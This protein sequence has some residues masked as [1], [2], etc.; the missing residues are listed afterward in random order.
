MNLIILQE[1][2]QDFDAVFQ[3][4]KMAFENEPISDKTEHYLV[5]RLRKSNA[6]I[7]ELS[8]VAETENRIIGHILLTKIQIKNTQNTFDS[9]A[10]APVSVH[11]VYQRKGVGAKLIKQ[12][13]KSA[14][15]LG[16]KAIILIGHQDYYPRFSYLPAHTFGIELPFKIPPENCMAIELVENG[17]KGVTGRV[18]YPAEFFT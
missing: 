4:I 12:A 1:I 6:F 3:L 9:F 11:P 8:L 7:P 18:E 10:L 17:L 16:Y 14:T 2:K 15:A 13:H 5:E